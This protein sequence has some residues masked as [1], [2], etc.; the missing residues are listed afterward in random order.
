[1][2]QHKTSAV[3]V[4]NQLSLIIRLYFRGALGC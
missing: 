2:H 4:F 3:A 1:M